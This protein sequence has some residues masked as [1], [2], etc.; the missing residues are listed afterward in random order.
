MNLFFEVISFLILNFPE[1]FLN[2]FK[3]YFLI[4]VINRYFDWLSHQIW[5]V[6]I[7]KQARLSKKVGVKGIKNEITGLGKVDHRSIS[8][9]NTSLL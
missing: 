3:C 6:L 7:T 9:T 4:F 5:V 2:G 8:E 1:G